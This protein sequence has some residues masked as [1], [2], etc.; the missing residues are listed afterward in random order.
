MRKKV[1]SDWWLVQNTRSNIVRGAMLPP[2]FPPS[3]NAGEDGAPGKAG[4]RNFMTFRDERDVTNEKSR[5][6]V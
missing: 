2:Q 3:P 1:A 4:R 5:L 6:I